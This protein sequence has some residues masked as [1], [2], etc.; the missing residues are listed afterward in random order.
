MLTSSSNFGEIKIQTYIALHK[1]VA[2]RIDCSVVSRHVR[3][4]VV[5]GA[6]ATI[7]TITPIKFPGF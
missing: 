3:I 1:T 7:T 5:V 6:V 4:T 2:Q